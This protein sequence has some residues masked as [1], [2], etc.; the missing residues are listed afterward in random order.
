MFLDQILDLNHCFLPQVRHAP[1]G[2]GQTGCQLHAR[3]HPLLRGQ[4]IRGHHHDGVL[5][6]RSRTRG[7]NNFFKLFEFKNKRKFS[8]F[9]TIIKVI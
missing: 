7:E 8:R 6:R 4:A 2:V 5:D 3:L 1:E 9:A